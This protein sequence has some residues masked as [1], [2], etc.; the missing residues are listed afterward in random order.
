MRRS[1]YLSLGLAAAVGAWMYSGSF[2]GAAPRPVER[3]PAAPPPMTVLVQ[4]A[5]SEEVT[6]LVVVQGQLEPLRRVEIRAETA[7]QVVELPVEKGTPVAAGTVLV[8]LAE[9]DRLAHLARAE[10]EVAARAV[11]VEG[12]RRLNAK[13][14]QGES[15]LKAAEAALAAAEADVKRLRLDLDKTR[16]TAPFD[17]VLEDRLV[18]RGSLVERGDAVAELVDRASL[19]A[20]G[21]VPQRNAGQ[22][23]VGQPVAVRLLDGRTAEGRVTF[24]AS[25]AE[26]GTRSFRIEARVP[27]AGDALPAGVSAELSVEV[28]KVSA[29]FLSP[30]ALT[31]DDHGRVGVKTVHPDSTV[32]FFPVSLVRTAAEG[33]WVTGLPEE[34]RVIVQGQ[35]FVTSGQRVEAV[36][37]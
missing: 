18:E 37:S 4:H 16:I 2:T 36:S 31:L 30:A 35:G 17:G 6:R 22:V 34:A 32:G 23:T 12:F 11:E 15:Q 7:G 21:Q 20:V 13:G 26:E 14:L 25:V 27:N 8:S 19:L 10:A 9:D 1:V 24:V 33:I 29:H 28:G 5:R 3:E